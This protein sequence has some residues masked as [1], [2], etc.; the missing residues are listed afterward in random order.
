MLTSSVALLIAGT[1]FVGHE[2]ISYRSQMI[3]HISTVTNVVGHSVAT[4]LARGDRVAAESAIWALSGEGHVAAAAVYTAAGEIFATYSRPDC[5][6]P[7]P[8]LD[9]LDDRRFFRDEH[10]HVFR[11]VFFGAERVGTIYIKS[12]KAGLASR[13]RRYAGTVLVITVASSLVAFFLSTRL[14]RLISDP[15]TQLA[16]VAKTVSSRKNY[17][18]RA[19]KR[20]QDEIGVLIDGFNEMLAQIQKRDLELA[21]RGQSLEADV[22]HRTAELTDANAELRVAKERAEAAAKAKSEFLANM[23]HE[24]RTPMNGIIGMTELVL[25]T[26]LTPEQ[27]EYLRIVK[28]S[29]DSLLVLINDILDFSKIEAGRLELSRIPFDPRECVEETIRTLALR[30]HQKGIELACQIPSDI[31]LQVVGDPGRLRQVIVNLVG[32]AI[33]FTHEGEVVVCVRTV[34]ETRHDVVLEFAVADTGIGIPKDQQKIV[35]EAFAQGD[36]STTRQYGGTGL[37]LAISLQLVHL[38]G[39]DI[40][41]ESSVG[42]GS[43]FRFTARFGLRHG[44]RRP[45][46]AARA[47]TKGLHALIV[48]DNATSRRILEQMLAGWGTRPIAASSADSAIAAARQAVEEG[49]TIDLAVID[50]GMPD[51]S[52]FELAAQLV[53]EL[54]L[55]PVR[56]LMLSSASG[57]RDT[58]ECERLRLG[59]CL[60]KPVRQSELLDSFMTVVGRGG[61]GALHALGGFTGESDLSGPPA[62]RSLRILLAEDNPV[63]QKVAVHLLERRGHHVSVAADGREAI[64]MLATEGPFDVV[65]MD[66]QMPKMSGIEATRRIRTAEKAGD[67]RIPIV[68]LTANAMKGDRETCLEAGMDAYLAKPIRADELLEVVERVF[69]QTPADGETGRST[70]PPDATADDRAAAA[71]G[72]GEGGGD[73][74][75]GSHIAAPAV[76]REGI[77][78]R[79]D[80]DWSLLA[81]LAETFEECYPDIERA[82]RDAL[83]RRDGEAL[84]REAHTLKGA[85]GNLGATTAIDATRRLETSGR[86]GDMISAEADWLELT[87][88]IARFRAALR[89]LVQNRAA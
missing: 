61:A 46:A 75:D 55:D 59:G 19:E 68:A 22:A 17:A 45:E 60:T 25:D 30:A 28:S 24:I 56:I 48:D 6:G 1:V 20:G 15:I 58:V 3:H 29:A 88:E 86:G 47:D 89:H 16:N 39:G 13:I 18:V 12:E 43:V 49:Q 65:L 74:A 62:P 10:L 57:Q 80:G 9:T 44:V 52:G 63:N 87:R 41:L 79:L 11:G 70:R 33:K 42:K 40:R 14:Q 69:E 76:D 67:R 71:S 81:E 27:A 23:S 31:P 26:K 66:V 35:F 77:L 64:R 32:N 51:R 50:V 37:G 54:S 8:S 7:F 73:G 4:A 5:N 38:M 53:R 72:P 85:L 83:A 84:A 34:S 36:G 78:A 82:I 21:R 2:F